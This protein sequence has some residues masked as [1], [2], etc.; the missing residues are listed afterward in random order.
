MNMAQ[1]S[2]GLLF[3]YLVGQELADKAVSNDHVSS[4]SLT[5]MP[6]T[7]AKPSTRCRISNL[8]CA[9]TPLQNGYAGKP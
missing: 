3:Q 7:R 9:K 4:P 5:H 1:S 8:T 2:M 6:E